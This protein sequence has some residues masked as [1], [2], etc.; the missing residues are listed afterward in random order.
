MT[1]SIVWPTKRTLTDAQLVQWA[2]DRWDT[3]EQN[4][5]TYN[6]EYQIKRPETPAEAR[7]FL[8]DNGDVTFAQEDRS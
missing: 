3:T 8:L 6:T 4:D 2:Q 7:T 1:H 5:P